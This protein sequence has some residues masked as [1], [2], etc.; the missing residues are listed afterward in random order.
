MTDK[1]LNSRTNYKFIDESTDIH[2]DNFKIIKPVK[3]TNDVFN[4][5]SMYP[6]LYC[7]VNLMSFNIKPPNE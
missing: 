6:N 1:N 3:H 4:I 5:Y 2:Y 7:D